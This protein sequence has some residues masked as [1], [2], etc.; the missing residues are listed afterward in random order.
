MW[1]F[2]VKF[3]HYFDY[4]LSTAETCFIFPFLDASSL[5]LIIT[6]DY[7]V[8]YFFCLHTTYLSA[9]FLSDPKT[10]SESL[11][12]I[13]F[14]LSITH[15]TTFSPCVSMWLVLP[16]AWCL[17]WLSWGF[18]SPFFWE[19]PLSLFWLHSFVNAL[20]FLFLGLVHFSRAPPSH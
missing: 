17:Q 15:P 3:I 6:S 12:S 10:Y 1:N 16:S 14:F 18:I 9:V 2:C 8:Y 11:C 13:Y 7:S 19:V 20:A 4:I 5:F